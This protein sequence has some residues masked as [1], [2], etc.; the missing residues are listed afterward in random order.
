M[1]L[2][3]ITEKSKKHSKKKRYILTFQIFFPLHETSLH[4][5]SVLLKHSSHLHFKY[6]HKHTTTKAND[7]GSLSENS[8]AFALSSLLCDLL[9]SAA[10]D[11]PLHPRIFIKTHFSHSPLCA[12][13]KWRKLFIYRFR[14]SWKLSPFPLAQPSNSRSLRDCSH[15]QQLTNDDISPSCRVS[16]ALR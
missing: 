11:F 13:C 15:Q 10:F 14:R 4:T 1:R 6:D 16:C 12:H 8:L 5:I 9:C 2:A 3:Y 7:G